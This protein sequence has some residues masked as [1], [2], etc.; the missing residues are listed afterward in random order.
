MLDTQGPEIRSGSFHDG[1]KTQF[2][3]GQEITL[4]V[5][6]VARN[7]QTNKLLF[8]TYKGLC[9]AV[10]PGSIILFDDG[11]IAAK[12]DSVAATAG[13]VKCT[14]LNSGLLGQKKGINIPGAEIKLPAMSDKDRADLKWGVENDVDMVAASFV[15]KGSD[16]REVRKYLSEMMTLHGPSPDHPLPKIVS[17]IESTE[18]L[19]NFS[20]ILR[21][22]DAIMVARGDL[23]VEIPIATLA[24]VQ[25]EIV[26]QCNLAGKP[27][28][29]ATQ[30]LDSM[31]DNPR[32][33]RAEVS[34]VTNAIYDG[35]DCVMLSGE[36]ANGKYPVESVIT[37]N[38]IVAEAEK[39]RGQ[40]DTSSDYRD[41]VVVSEDTEG[42]NHN[43]DLMAMAVVE[44]A[45]SSDAACI[46]VVC[47]SGGTATAIAAC[48]PHIPVVAFV[49][50]AKLGR[51]LQLYRSLHPV[52]S[53]KSLLGGGSEIIGH[54]AGYCNKL[55]VAKAGDRV[56]VVHGQEGCET[57]AP[58]ISMSIALLK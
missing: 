51:Q 58:S 54:A 38:S 30:M 55:G 27:V 8:V 45:N 33:T 13:T 50:D 47:K 57:L 25:K 56:I 2:E 17:K 15:R 41:F 44:A 32:P 19:T 20:E 22:S 10:R 29:V 26:H 24:N 52:C 6:E 43:R 40:L 36:S 23:G 21:E 35:A 9:E 1:K 16:V 18:A 4:T 7:A 12:V 3:T 28:V 14:V 48:R 46:A 39:W 31:Q 37:M 5:D 34:D 42:E 11:A 53:P 49:P